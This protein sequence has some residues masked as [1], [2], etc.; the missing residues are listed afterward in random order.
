MQ[1]LVNFA[2]I[3]HVATPTHVSALPVLAA[4]ERDAVAA[5]LAPKS[6]KATV[7]VAR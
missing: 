1:A 3:W 4:G 6:G 2:V 7:V 5:V